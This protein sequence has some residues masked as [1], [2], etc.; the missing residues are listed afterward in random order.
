VDLVA[1]LDP[2]LRQALLPLGRHH[3][4][5]SGLFTGRLVVDGRALALEATGSRDHS[6]GSR[7]WNAADHWRLFVGRLGDELAFHALN[8]SCRGRRVAGGFV[9]D[10]RRA[11]ALQRVE[12]AVETRD[13]RVSGFDLELLA[14]DGS[15]FLLRGD[16]ERRVTIPVQAER[17]PLSLLVRGPYALCLQ[18]NFTRYRWAG[19]AG[20]GIAEFTERPK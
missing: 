12:H 19:R 13:G 2:E 14:R 4:E 20:H 18:E 17:R 7:D 11:R 9:W 1:G 16:V 15:R 3:V 10:G 8:V 6:W 5:Q